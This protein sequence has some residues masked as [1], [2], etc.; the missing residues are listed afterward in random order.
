VGLV[1]LGSLLATGASAAPYFYLSYGPNGWKPETY[2][3]LLPGSQTVPLWVDAGNV[4]STPGTACQS[5][6]GEELCG[7]AL[8]LE[9][10]GAVT[11][12]GFVP[13]PEHTVVS[14][15]SASEWRGSG[16]DVEN[17]NLGLTKIGDL[18]VNLSGA[19]E[20]WLRPSEAVDAALG[21]EDVPERLL[22]LPE[23]GGLTLLGP[24]VGLLWLLGR[25]R[26]RA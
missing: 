4:P 22:A 11:I 13:A 12:E 7:W 5:G 6:L 14:S 16:G 21:S 9:T 8:H 3:P 2:L 19:G 20:V 18:V 26:M 15:F 17:G 1:A 24:G 23:P 25:R 10:V